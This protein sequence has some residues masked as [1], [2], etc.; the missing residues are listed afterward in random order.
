MCRHSTLEIMV[1]KV[2]KCANFQDLLNSRYH[3]A[4]YGMLHVHKKQPP[5]FTNV[6]WQNTKQVNQ[7]TATLSTVSKDKN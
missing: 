6:F 4:Y 5:N 2:T 7:L 3:V 1:V